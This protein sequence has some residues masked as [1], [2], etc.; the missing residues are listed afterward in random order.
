MV[1]A[2]SATRDRRPESVF[3]VEKLRTVM[4][5]DELGHGKNPLARNTQFELYVAGL[6]AESGFE[7]SQGSTDATWRYL[8]ED[9][10]IEAKRL[11]SLSRSALD[12][13]LS[14]AAGQIIGDEVHPLFSL[15][16]NRGLI[17]VNVDAYFGDIAEREPAAVSDQMLFDRMNVVRVACAPLAQKHAILGVMVFGYSAHWTMEGPLGVPALEQS[18]PTMWVHLA[19]SDPGERLS[20][21]LLERVLKKIEERIAYLQAR[22]PHWT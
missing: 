20:R 19:G 21:K 17:A 15:A 14:K 3:T 16:R 2:A 10:C 7:V 8:G 22:V 13:R 18:Y 5:G 9:L 4:G 12:A 6:F 1:I 11:T